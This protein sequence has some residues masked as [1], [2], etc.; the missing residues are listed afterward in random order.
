MYIV[1]FIHMFYFQTVRHRCPSVP[2]CDC[3]V[4]VLGLLTAVHVQPL[5]VFMVRSL[6][7]FYDYMR[8]FSYG[9]PIQV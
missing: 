3:C 5:P 1:V 9:L 4:S 7:V 8:P 2:A 6:N